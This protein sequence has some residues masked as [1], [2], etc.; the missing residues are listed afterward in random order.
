MV[1][2][3]ISSLNIT[4]ALKIA[5]DAEFAA[6]ISRGEIRSWSRHADPRRRRPRPLRGVDPDMNVVAL[7]D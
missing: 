6:E 7:C 3:D 1:R 4:V 5:V 2:V